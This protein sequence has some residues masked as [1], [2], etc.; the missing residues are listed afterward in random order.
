[1][2]GCHPPSEPL[3]LITGATSTNVPGESAI[4]CVPEIAMFDFIHISRSQ[5]ARCSLG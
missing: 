2:S 1:M 3:S 4:G 5:A